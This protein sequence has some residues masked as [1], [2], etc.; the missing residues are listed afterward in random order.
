MDACCVAIATL[1]ACMGSRLLSCPRLHA[2]G[3]KEM[4]SEDSK[5]DSSVALCAVFVRAG[6]VD[7]SI[8][9]LTFHDLSLAVDHIGYH[10]LHVNSN[11]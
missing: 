10:P 11:A 8:P 1:D 7:D 3:S 4:R 6:H 2:R 9:M 5:P